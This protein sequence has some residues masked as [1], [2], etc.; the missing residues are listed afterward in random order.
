[1][2]GKEAKPEP[3]PQKSMKELSRDFTK[4]IKKMQREFDREIFKFEQS[5]TKIRNDVRKML[6]KGE[7][8]NNI[9]LVAGNI[10][11][12]Q[13]FIKKYQ[14]LNAQLNDVLYQIQSSATTETM[15]EV[16]K[17][18]RDVFTSNLNFRC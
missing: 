17:G 14:R 4:K 9:R 5:N 1:M 11:K 6:E 2:G 18:M 7:S 13:N 15:V 12:N 8:K 3:V 10:R 16:M